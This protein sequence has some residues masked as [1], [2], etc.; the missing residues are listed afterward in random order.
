[1]T[2]EP[3]VSEPRVSTVERA[4]KAPKL[5]SELPP[6]ESARASKF[7]RALSKFARALRSE[8]ALLLTLEPLLPFA[9]ALSLMLELSSKF[10]SRLTVERASAS[11]RS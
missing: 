2:V 7:A 9:R 4:S 5:E 3:L 1:M 6:V 10:G 8:F 11:F